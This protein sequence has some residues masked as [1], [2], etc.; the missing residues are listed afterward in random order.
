M[1][2]AEVK[3]I[4]DEIKVATGA[5]LPKDVVEAARDKRSPIHGWFTWDQNAAAEKCRLE[6]ARQLIRSVY[7]VVETR[8]PVKVRAYVSLPEDRVS[9]KGYR[10]IATV[11]DDEALIAQL[12]REMRDKAAFWENQARQLG[13]VADFSSV[14]QLADRI[15]KRKPAQRTTKIQRQPPAAL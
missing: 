7:I 12:V 13:L 11:I 14:R 3:Q 8:P 5:L 2:N 9:G 10:E 1:D 6:E 15:E 4:L